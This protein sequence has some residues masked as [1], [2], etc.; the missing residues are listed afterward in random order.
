MQKLIAVICCAFMLC[1]CDK[2]DPI[3]PGT[4]TAIFE[5]T[6][7]Q[8]ADKTITDIP[9][10][11][12]TYD[13]SACTY[14]QDSAN[15]V[16]DGSRRVFSGFPTNN[17]VS[18]KTRPVCDGKYLYAGLTTGELVKLNPKTRQI[19]W[20]ADIYRASN[21]TGG[22][23]VVDIVVPIVPNG[24]YVYAGGLGDAFCK[25]ASATGDK[26]WCL[27]IGVSVPFIIAGDY[28]FVVATDDNLYAIR[29][30][31]GTVFWRVAVT[32]QVAPEYKSSQIRV[33]NIVYNVAD[34]KIIDKKYWTK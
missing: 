12:F 31:D 10:T 32:G 15:V 23:S 26:Q 27:D 17:T 4:R 29:T 30:T 28:A 5:G 9:E 3:L 6:Q 11:A 21:L 14:T 19:I 7:I 13:N 25:L 1:A 8:V 34:G 33:G 24:K 2:H 22:A 16:W 20:I 18:A